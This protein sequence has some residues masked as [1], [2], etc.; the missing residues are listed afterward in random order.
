M[1]QSY[2]LLSQFCPDDYVP[3]IK[4][5]LAYDALCPL[6]CTFVRGSLGELKYAFDPSPL[7]WS[8]QMEWPWV[9]KEGDFKYGQKVLD[10]G[11]GWSVLKYA[12]ARRVYD[13]QMGGVIAL[14]INPEFIERTKPSIEKMKDIGI[15]GITQVCGDAVALPFP[16][17]YF[18]R[19]VSVS[20]LEHIPN[21]HLKCVQEMVRVL[22]PG[23]LALFSMDMVVEGN[24]GD[25]GNFYVSRKEVEEILRYLEIFQVHA[26]APNGP[27][28]G[29][30][31]RDEKV[32]VVCVMIKY[33]KT[34]G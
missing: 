28:V 16:H 23:G 6:S 20:V 34:G 32:Q 24:P 1:N 22:K 17:H 10:I 2:A 14:D 5:M 15:Y 7:H 19:V 8:R 31:L 29:A 11:S 3:V 26:L 9:I 4:E 21:A 33:I 13:G 25:G 27:T 18:D 30:E 12:M